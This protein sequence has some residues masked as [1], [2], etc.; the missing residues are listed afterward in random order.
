MYG[1]NAGLAFGLRN[2]LVLTARAPL[3]YVSQRGVDGFIL[4]ASAGIRGRVYRRNRTS[5][6]LELDVGICEADTV[7]PPR[8]TRANYLAMGGV[9]VTI[10]VRRDVH[11]LAAMRWTHVSNGARAGRSRNPDIEAVGP[12]VGVVMGF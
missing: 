9:G 1:F 10:R 4:G 8:G 7:V 11:I 2:G 5:L 6:F 12:Q 3:Y